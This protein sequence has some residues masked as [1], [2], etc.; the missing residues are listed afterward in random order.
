MEWKPSGSI[1]RAAQYKRKEVARMTETAT[2][3][4]ADAT[5]EFA[6]N[7]V[8]FPVDVIEADLRLGEIDK[9]HEGQHTARWK[10]IAEYITSLA[11]VPCAVSQATKFY[12][13]ITARAAEFWA[14]D[15]KKPTSTPDSPAISDSTPAPS[16]T[17]SD[18]PC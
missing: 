2:I 14:D 9:Q 16:P 8:T 17:A 12:R 1:A 7:G 10:A 5:V 11:G 13:A 6:I 4:L 18:A 3:P 15:K